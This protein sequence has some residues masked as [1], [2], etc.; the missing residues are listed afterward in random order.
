MRSRLDADSLMPFLNPE[1]GL[2]I[3]EP[4][5]VIIG[6]GLLGLELAASLRQI[7]VRV[8]VIQRAGLKGDKLVGAVPVG[9]KNEFAEFRELIASGLE[10][11]DK[12][13]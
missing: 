4:H 3:I 2:P 5:C 13:L 12:R 6:G 8:T 9:D 1:A 11:S 7:G 10:L